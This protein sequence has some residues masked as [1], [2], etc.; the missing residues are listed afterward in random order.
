MSVN[1][2]VERMES[3]WLQAPKAVLRMVL[4]IGPPGVGKSTVATYLARQCPYQNVVLDGDSLAM[5]HPGGT[6]RKRLDLIERN[7]LHCA[8]GYRL[9]GAHYS[10]C[11][12]IVAHQHRLDMLEKRMRAKGIHLRV[13]ALDAPVNVLV[14][15]MMAR[16]QARFSPTENNRE[17]LSG[18]R[19]RIRNLSHCE[20]ID[21]TG[22]HFTSVAQDAAAL[23]KKPSFWAR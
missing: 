4:L 9:W 17:Y 8:E 18:I 5:T 1:L 21:T 16:P 22:K 13:I 6:D 3:Q 15:R 23:I 10:F 2:E 11:S 12:W 14:D 19:K 7:M 20:I